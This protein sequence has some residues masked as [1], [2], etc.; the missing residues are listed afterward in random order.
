MP[1]P[2]AASYKMM[3]LSTPPD[4]APTIVASAVEM[5]KALPTPQPARKPT[6]MFTELD[7]PAAAANA[8]ISASPISRV[9]LAPIRLATTLVKHIARPVIS[10]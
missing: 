7:A 6:I 2:S 5:N 1:R 4:A 3:A 10:R 9:G 8:T